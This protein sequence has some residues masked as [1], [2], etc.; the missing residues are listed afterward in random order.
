[1]YIHDLARKRDAKSI[2]KSEDNLPSLAAL[3]VRI[4]M[5][6][7]SIIISIQIYT[8]ICIYLYTDLCI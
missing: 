7:S 1:M 6:S 3:A 5:V 2:M 8:S 4:Y